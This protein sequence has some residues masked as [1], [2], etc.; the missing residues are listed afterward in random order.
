[1][2]TNLVLLVNMQCRYCRVTNKTQY[3]QIAVKIDSL[4]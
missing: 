1:M 3:I 4:F 2:V